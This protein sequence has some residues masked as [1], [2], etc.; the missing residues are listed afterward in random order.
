MLFRS[1]P[2][3]GED[4]IIQATEGSAIV[5]LDAS[6]TEDDDEQIDS[7]SWIDH[8][9]NTIAESYQCKVKLPLGTYRF[10]FRIRDKNGMWSTDSIS[11]QIIE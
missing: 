1:I 7:I 5:H 10:E 3:A 8:L 2:R 11:I 9:G 4:L 6:G